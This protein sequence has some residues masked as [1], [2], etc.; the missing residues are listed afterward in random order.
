MVVKFPCGICQKTVGKKHNLVCFD[1]CNE[2]IHIACNDLDKKTYKLLQGS[3]TKW[4]CINCTE[5]EFP[6]TSQ[7]NQELEKIY[8]GKHV[9]PYKVSEIES[10]TAKINNRISH[11]NDEHII[12]S[13]YYNINELNGKLNESKSIFKKTFSLM[14]L[15]ISSLQYHLDEL[16]DLIDKSEATFSVIG[17]TESHLNKDIVPLN[18]VNLHNFN[19]QHTPTE[20][21]YFISQQ[22][23]VTKLEMI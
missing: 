9:I 11:E 4:F 19:I 18:N 14:H 21:L 16:S 1:L 3:S 5:K 12:K 17:I 20:S 23:S 2:W 8:S 13:L 10:F 15:N 6:F 7:T 22:T